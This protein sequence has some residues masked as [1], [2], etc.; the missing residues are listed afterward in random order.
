HK[1]TLGNSMPG[2]GYIQQFLDRAVRA[3]CAYALIEVT[4]QGVV[5]HRHRFVDWNMGVLTNLAP[6]HIEAHGSFENYRK[7]KLDF[8]KYVLKKGGKVF[9]NRDDVSYAFM[10]IALGGKAAE[11]SKNDVWLKNYLPKSLS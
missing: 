6:E 8:L 9:L 1:N 7:A 2:R 10:T 5:A 3:G 11:F 4:S